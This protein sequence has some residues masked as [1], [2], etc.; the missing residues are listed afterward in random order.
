MYNRAKGIAVTE[1]IVASGGEVGKDAHG[2]L[3]DAV[4]NAMSSPEARE[5]LAKCDSFMEFEKGTREALREGAS[6]GTS[7]LLTEADAEREPLRCGDCRRTMVRRSRPLSALWLLGRLRVVRGYW[8][9]GCAKGGRCPLDEEL[10]VKGRDGTRATP[11]LVKA[12]APLAAETAFAPAAALASRLLGF[13]VNAKWMERMAKRLGSEMAAADASEQGVETAPAPSDAMCCGIDGT[14]VPV[15]PGELSD[16]QGK[17]GGKART[18]EAK[19]A[20]FGSGDGATWRSAAIDSAASRDTDAEPSAFAA[21]LWREARRSGFAA[22]R[23]KAVLGDGA[24]WIRGVA[25]ELFPGAVEIV[26]LWHAKEHV[27]EV[28]RSVHGAGTALCE[29]WSERTCAALSEGRLDDVLAALRRH[30][31]NEEALRCAGYVEANRARM[32][33]PAFRAAGL[34]VGSGVVESACGAVAGRLKRGGMR[35]SVESGANPMLALR[36]RWLDGRHDEF[37]KA[38]ARPPPLALAA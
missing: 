10:G 20:A 12:V 22:A 8:T 37:F 34:P 18:R 7:K 32:N 30:A 3:R 4:A 9:C 26:D 31:D 25:S 6:A 13:A 38:R 5:A 1:G 15:R 23:V 21:R 24:K 16:S 14:G 28:G 33:Y 19:L 36:C 27:W 2:F 11:G 35:W 29:A 17:D